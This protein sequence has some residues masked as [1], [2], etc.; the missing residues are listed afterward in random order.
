MF[1]MA[2]KDYQRGALYLAGRCLASCKYLQPA[3]NLGK[4]VKEVQAGPEDGGGARFE[5]VYS[6]PRADIVI[7]SLHS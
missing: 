7:G 4:P 2:V 5:Q 1:K 6:G 3:P